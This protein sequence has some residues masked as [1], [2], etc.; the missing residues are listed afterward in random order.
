L[1]NAINYD[2]NMTISKR[3][4]APSISSDLLKDFLSLPR[5][6]RTARLVGRPWLPRPVNALL[7]NGYLTWIWYEAESGGSAVP[8]KLQRPRN[9]L[10]FAFAQLA[11]ASNE[12][13]REFAARWGPLGIESR[14]EAADEWRRWAAVAQALLR[15]AVETAAHGTGSDEAWNTICASLPVVSLDR[16]K[17]NRR[18]QL[19]IAAMAV[20]TWYAKARGH[21]I[22]DVMPGQFQIQPS[23]SNLFG[24]LAAQV[25]HAMAR[26]DQKAQCAECKVLFTPKRPISNGKRQYCSR[27]RREQVPQRD[28]ARDWRSR[29]RQREP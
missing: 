18:E 6:S 28:A 5:K 25:A 7:R 24:V 29:K 19:A 13:I 17:W 21:R 10:C 20:N 3:P 2:V 22:L 27:C 12:E 1:F 16:C 26:S 23:A 4:S 9:D 15:F 11:H 14:E 8:P